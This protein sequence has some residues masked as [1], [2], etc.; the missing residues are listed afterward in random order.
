MWKFPGQGSNLCHRSDHARSLT[1]R[2]PGNAWKLLI[3]RVLLR[4]WKGLNDRKKQEHNAEDA[5]PS[6]GNRSSRP[7]SPFHS[8]GFVCVCV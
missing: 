1:V 6:L 3:L 7:P 2:P 5:V 8:S 4:L